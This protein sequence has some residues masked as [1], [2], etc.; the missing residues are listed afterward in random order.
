MLKKKE[1]NYQTKKD[2]AENLFQALLEIESEVPG[3]NVIWYKEYTI[4]HPD[5]SIIR[6]VDSNEKPKMTGVGIVIATLE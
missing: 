3:K 4:K 6:K 1:F 2:F 5:G